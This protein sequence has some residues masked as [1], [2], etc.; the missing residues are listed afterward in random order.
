MVPDEQTAWLELQNGRVAFAPVPPDQLAAART[1]HGPSA[2][3]RTSPGL[4]QGPTLTTWQL[5]FNLKSKLGGNPTWRQAVSLA[6]DRDQLA[7]ALAG[8]GGDDLVP[9]ATPGG[10]SGGRGGPTR[11]AS[12]LRPRPGQGPRPVRQGQGGSRPGHHGHPARRRRPPRRRPG[13]RRPDR[14]RGRPGDHPVP[15]GRDAVDAGPPGRPLPPPRPVPRRPR[16]RPSPTP[17]ASSTRPAPPPT[18]PPA[19]PSTSRPKPP[20]WPPSPPP[21]SSPSTTPP[22][23]P[24]APRASTSPPGAPSTWPPSASPPDPFDP[25]ALCYNP[26]APRCTTS[27]WRNRQTR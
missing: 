23:S 18:T 7:T 17:G 26:P 16:P 22:S 11:P 13:R 24:P 21:P 2:D 14:R 5:T 3:G 25:Q 12:G 20:P 8:I 9:P 4:L 1:V 15:E 10:G 19:P 27:E 6:I